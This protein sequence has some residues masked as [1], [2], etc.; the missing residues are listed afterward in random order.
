MD[1]SVSGVRNLLFWPNEKAEQVK[2]SAFPPFL[3]KDF[4]K[5]SK[6]LFLS[7]APALVRVTLI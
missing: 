4:K 1:S 2:I 6:G 7:R 5:D 3:Y